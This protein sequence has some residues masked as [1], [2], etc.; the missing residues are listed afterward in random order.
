V[1]GALP[2]SIIILVA[3]LHGSKA[4]A[5]EQVGI[6]LCCSLPADNQHQ[7]RLVSV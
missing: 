3:G 2:D 6:A 5:H 7:Q 1:I 4:M